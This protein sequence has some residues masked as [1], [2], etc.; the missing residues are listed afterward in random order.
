LS[1][2]FI[3]ILL[4]IAV[5]LGVASVSIADESKSLYYEVK[6]KSAAFGDMGT[7]KVWIKGDKM[8]WEWK[9]AK[10]P[11]VI[12]KNPKGVFLLHPWNKI[13]AQYPSDSRRGDPVALLPGPAGPPGQFLKALNAK[14]CGK[15][16]INKQPCKVYSYHEP[17]TKRDCMLWL[18]AKTG[19]P[20]K[21]L[22]KG[23]EKKIDTVTAFYTRFVEDAKIADSFLDLPKGFTIRPMPRLD[24]TSKAADNANNNKKPS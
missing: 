20:V 7:R 4:C 3:P 23:K 16:N 19:K 8:R 21:L 13:A 6:L 24:F 9:S 10:L 15:E 11:I 12:V 22:V 2:K 5:S 1:R 14:E 18:D 17:T